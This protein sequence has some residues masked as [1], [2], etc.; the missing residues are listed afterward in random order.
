MKKRVVMDH[1]VEY[2]W[3]PIF[4]SFCK[5]I[6]HETKDCSRKNHT[7]IMPKRKR[8]RK[9]IW[10]QKNTQT[11]LFHN[12]KQINMLIN[13]LKLGMGLDM[14]RST[15]SVGTTA[16]NRNLSTPRTT[17]RCSMTQ[18]QGRMTSWWMI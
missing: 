16:D 14:R 17:S 18:L 8:K 2:V 11:H 6:S 10:I 13:Q 4:F 7:Q 1:I 5:G 3:L 9:R 15:C 12:K